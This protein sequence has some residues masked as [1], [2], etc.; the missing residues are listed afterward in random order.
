MAYKKKTTYFHVTA[1][2]NGRPFDLYTRETDLMGIIKDYLPAIK[3]GRVSKVEIRL[4][5]NKKKN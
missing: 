2:I 4:Y 5:D 3:N 1:N